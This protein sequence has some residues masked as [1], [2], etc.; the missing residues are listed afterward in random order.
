MV[1]TRAAVGRMSRFSLGRAVALFVLL[2]AVLSW[3]TMRSA[4]EGDR[5]GREHIVFWAGWLLG[6]DIYGAIDRFEKLHPEYRVTAT[7]SNAT[8][9]AAQDATGDAQR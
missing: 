5:D 9:G 7:T 2:A 8:T 6:D 1:S 3:W 4:D